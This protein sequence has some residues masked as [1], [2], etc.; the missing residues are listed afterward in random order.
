MK[1]TPVAMLWEYISTAPGLARWFADEVIQQGK[2]FTFI[3]HRHPQQALMTARR[4]ESHIRFRW[5][6]EA[7]EAGERTY[8]EMRIITSEMSDNV[9]LQITDF[10]DEGEEDD[11]AELWESQIDTL[12]RAIGC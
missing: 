6:E 9:S 12:R 10:A 2:R 11:Q 7:E 5:D 8:F 1:R 3:W 4:E